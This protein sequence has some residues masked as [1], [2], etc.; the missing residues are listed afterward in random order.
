MEKIKSTPENWSNRKLGAEE[1]YVAVSKSVDRIKLDECLGMQMIS[2]R[3]DKGLIEDYKSLGKKYGLGY[4]TLMKQ[5]LKRFAD[6]ELKQLARETL[7]PLDVQKDKE[8]DS[9][10]VELEERRCI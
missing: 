7:K 2:I 5:I 3:L 8:N 10:Y 1:K 9:N 6:A 4:Q